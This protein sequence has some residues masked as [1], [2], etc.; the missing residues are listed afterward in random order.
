MTSADDSKQVMQTIFC[1]LFAAMVIVASLPVHAKLPSTNTSVTDSQQEPVRKSSVGSKRRTEQKS[2]GARKTQAGTQSGRLVTVN[3]FLKSRN[4]KLEVQ[5]DGAT[6]STGRTGS[7]PAGTVK[8]R[9]TVLALGAVKTKKAILAPGVIKT[10]KIVLAPGT[11]KKTLAK[12]TT[13]G[14]KG[15]SSNKIAVRK[16]N[17]PSLQAQKPTAKVSPHVSSGSKVAIQNK[18][19]AREKPSVSTKPSPHAHTRATVSSQR[20]ASQNQSAKAA[21]IKQTAKGAATPRVVILYPQMKDAKSVSHKKSTG[22]ESAKSSNTIHD[23]ASSK[24]LGTIAKPSPPTHS[25][26][27]YDI[28]SNQES[29]TERPAAKAAVTPRVVI[30]YPQMKEAKSVSQ[31]KSDES[32][33]AKSLSSSHD[34]ASS[35]KSTTAAKPSPPSRATVTGQH[36]VSKK[37]E[38]KLVTKKQVSVATPR[39]VILYPLMK[40]SKSVSRR[41]SGKIELAKSGN[42]NHKSARKKLTPLIGHVTQVVRPTPTQQ[43]KP[44]TTLPPQKAIVTNT[45]VKIVRSSKLVVPPEP[46]NLNIKQTVTS[47]ST[48]EHDEG[49]LSYINELRKRRLTIPIAGY[50]PQ[51]MRGF[52]YARRGKRIHSAADLLTP[53][54]TP[55]LAVEA[56]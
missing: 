35:K 15:P 21:T 24:K 29:K 42:E 31:T 4:A 20:S 14:P 49:V 38:A 32:G 36:D 11:V 43:Q 34:T 19:S 47:T 56:G 37:Q 23:T 13:P 27:R 5:G 17:K 39:V 50:A 10:K 40:N 6:E 26:G 9:K 1:A 44:V 33:L 45:A 2:N 12:R 22:S 55:I 7:V 51:L 25:D 30:L 16:Q 3:R 52:F 48:H 28:S 53:R 18:G 41:K 8:T 54:N 46:L